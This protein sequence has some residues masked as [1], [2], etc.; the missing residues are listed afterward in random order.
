M[1]DGPPVLEVGFEGCFDFPVLDEVLDYV[2]ERGGGV[3]FLLR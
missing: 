1:I 2:F 3:G